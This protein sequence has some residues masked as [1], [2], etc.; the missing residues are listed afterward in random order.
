MRAMRLP[1][2]CTA[3]GHWYLERGRS[4]LLLHPQL[5]HLQRHRP[6]GSPMCPM[7]VLKT[8]RMVLQG[9]QHLVCNGCPS[10]L[11]P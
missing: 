3:L 5:K 8:D 11:L 9:K 1:P 6:H 7:R 2:C 10:L 4:S